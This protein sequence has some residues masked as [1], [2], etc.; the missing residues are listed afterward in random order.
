MTRPAPFVC[1]ACYPI[2]MAGNAFNSTSAVDV[3]QLHA[4]KRF[5]TTPTRSKLLRGSAKL[6]EGLM[7]RWFVLAVILGYVVLS[8]IV[9]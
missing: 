3:Q 7:I 4:T 8:L 6:V 5:T 1:R 2:E 9:A